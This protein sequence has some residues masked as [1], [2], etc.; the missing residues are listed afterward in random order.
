MPFC[1]MID[2]MP[3]AESE[4]RDLPSRE[5]PVGSAI[6]PPIDLL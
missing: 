6:G 1:S 2:H 4:G 5:R 3:R